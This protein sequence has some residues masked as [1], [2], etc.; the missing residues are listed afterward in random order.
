MNKISLKI[1]G[2]IS[3]AILISVFFNTHNASANTHHPEP[4]S[5]EID[6]AFGFDKSKGIIKNFNDKDNFIITESSNGSNNRLNYYAENSKNWMS[7]GIKGN[8]DIYLMFNPEKI[9]SDG[10]KW[11]LVK[12]DET[13]VEGIKLDQK[14]G[15]GTVFV[16]KKED[17][18]NSEWKMVRS[19][20]DFLSG[21]DHKIMTI[22]E[23]EA[24]NGAY[25]K[26]V[27]AY[28]VEGKYN[29]NK[30]KKNRIEEYYFYLTS[31]SNWVYFKNITDPLG[32]NLKQEDEVDQGFVIYKNGSMANISKKY[33][34]GDEIPLFIG[35][36]GNVSICDPGKWTIIIRTP[37]GIRY[38]YNITVKNGCS[39]ID[40]NPN[41]YRPNNEKYI[42]SSN[43]KVSKTVFDTNLTTAYVIQQGEGIKKKQSDNGET[44]IGVNGDAV[45][46]YIQ[47]NKN[48]NN[49]GNG[50]SIISDSYGA[51]ATD[52]I[53]GVRT[54][55]VKSGAIIIKKSA[56][57]GATWQNCTFKG[58]TYENGYYT[59]DFT[60]H[61]PENNMIP[62][63][64]P[65]GKQESGIT[66][67]DLVNGVHIK[68]CF[69]YKVRCGDS[70]KSY[71][72]IEEYRFYL[73]NNNVGA[74]TFKNLTEKDIKDLN[75]GSDKVQFD[76]D[77]YEKTSTIA[78]GDMTVT[79]FTVD[80]SLNPKATVTVYKD[81]KQITDRFASKEYR[82]IGKY[83]I[84]VTSEYG[85]TRETTIYVD[86]STPEESIEK[87][88]KDCTYTMKRVY[89]VN[90]DYPVFQSRVSVFK[91]SEI[92]ESM[93]SIKGKVFKDGKEIPKM[94]FGPT[95]KS[96][97]L[98]FNECG[99]YELEIKTCNDAYETVSGD[100][101]IFR[102]R[103]SIVE[104]G[105]A[106]SINK[107]KLD[108]YA[109]SYLQDMVPIYY[110]VGISS[111]AGGHII[112]AFPDEESA[113]A[114]AEEKAMDEVETFNDKVYYTD[115]SDPFGIKKPI[116]NGWDLAESSAEN[117]K[118]K[119]RELYID[120]SKDTFY[121]I[122]TVDKKDYE[123]GVNYSALEF[124]NTVLI[125]NEET[126]ALLYATE[127][128]ALPL[129]NDKI[130]YIQ[131]VG[132]SAK[133]KVYYEGFKFE[134][135][136]GESD[137]VIVRDRYGNE[138]PLKYYQKVGYQLDKLGCA[139]G[140]I[141]IMERNRSL[142]GKWDGDLTGYPALYIAPND[143]QCEVGIRIY[144]DFGYTDVKVN[145]NSLGETP[146]KTR[147]FEISSFVDNI[148]DNY[149]L[150]MIFKDGEIKEAS[151]VNPEIKMTFD[152]SGVYFVK[153][154]NRAGY[155]F[156]FEVEVD[157]SET[158]NLYDAIKIMVNEI[159][160]IIECIG[161]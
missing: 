81:G 38:E 2:I 72:F 21:N 70:D 80:K 103:F 46:V 92:S 146:I 123:D 118:N 17:R 15:K 100:V 108:E 106:P 130:K 105:N 133:Q 30:I 71:T 44:I 40:L 13:I 42:Y 156:D 54:G 85:D 74:V 9:Y 16:L 109:K 150:I 4:E 87:Y 95:R 132:K 88:F 6:T 73:C 141:W 25:Y 134:K 151:L 93:Q 125:P 43:D 3:F 89:E 152:D 47:L 112:V 115:P 61:Y 142:E 62:I 101:R 90:S 147:K 63:Y 111:A 110:G 97:E 78:S 22:N 104:K 58:T 98:K 20:Y 75:L 18:S 66:E 138:Y 7:Y 117:A 37:S 14:V 113:R 145:R 8:A 159:G 48:R 102:F 119:I 127:L 114:Y 64:I 49:L 154:I 136:D 129:I 35:S 96:V 131:P 33:N 79:G 50:W 86:P 84:A 91:T 39:K 99:S 28:S 144:G 32:K 143:N 29:G 56:D 55:E 57:N 59:T 19:S 160:R 121:P 158:G 60:Y 120:T 34:D 51:Q 45:G 122:R 26:I 12:S 69:Y 83:T 5:Y 24:Q 68:L 82:E 27:V 94:E 149:S 157:N 126:E 148:G 116:E 137:S 1:F 67:D 36:N 65:K 23:S 53:D 52:Y 41:I 76:L 139:S 124:A 155:S 10:I 161:K 31:E 153:C 128:G 135:N 11:E 140:R 107:L 77:F